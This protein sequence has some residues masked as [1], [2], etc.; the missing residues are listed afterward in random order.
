MQNQGMGKR[1]GLG[2]EENGETRMRFFVTATDRQAWIN[3]R[4]AEIAV[5]DTFK[6]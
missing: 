3:S 5:T 2:Y 1:F 6:K 4:G